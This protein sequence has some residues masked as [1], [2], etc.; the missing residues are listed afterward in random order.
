MSYK[1]VE[2]NGKP[3]I[4]EGD[5]GLRIRLEKMTKSRAHIIARKLNLGAGFQGRTPEFFANNFSLEID[6]DE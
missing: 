1:V 2:Q 4:E 3:Y 6:E 5:T